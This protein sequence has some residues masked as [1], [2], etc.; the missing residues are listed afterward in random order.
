MLGLSINESPPGNGGNDRSS[1]LGSAGPASS[2]TIDSSKDTNAKFEDSIKYKEAAST[3]VEQGNV[4]SLSDETLSF[5]FTDLNSD[6]RRPNYV[7]SKQYNRILKRRLAR[8]ELVE[9]LLITS[10]R[11][12]YLH[13]L[14]H[15]SHARRRP[16]EPGGR[17]LTPDEIVEIERVS[18]GSLN[19]TPEQMHEIVPQS[20]ITP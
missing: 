2:N 6:D 10:N 3:I 7:N 4:G 15:G 5:I 8:D 12:P 11:K 14:R 17:F 16:R 19:L 9:K 18:P 13:E 20:N 1:S